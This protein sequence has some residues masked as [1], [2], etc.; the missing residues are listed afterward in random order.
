MNKKCII[1]GGGTRFHV[2]NHL[3][4]G[5]KAGGSTA[6]KI[7]ELVKA[8]PLNRMD[9]DLR[10]TNMALGGHEAHDL[11]TPDDVRRVAYEVVNDPLTKVVFMNCAIVDFEWQCGDVPAGKYSKRL[12]THPTNPPTPHPVME[13][14]FTSTK[15]LPIFR[16]ERNEAGNIRKDIF[17]VAFKATCGDTN[18]VMFEKG[19]KCLKDN[20]ANLVLVNDTK[21]RM[22]MIITPEEAV[23]HETTNRDE[24][25]A[26]LV[27]MTLHRSQL[28]FTQS[29]VID[30]SPVSWDDPQIPNSLREVVDFCIAQ[31]AYKPMQG[32]TVGHF[33][34]K[35][36]DQTF[37]TSKR[38]SNFNKLKE[39]GLVKIV[40]DG[41]DT[42]LA[43]GAKPSVGGQS[44]RM[45]FSDHPGMDCIVH[46]HCPLNEFPQDDI[47]VVSQ[48]EVECGSHQ[49]G[50]N[51]SNGLKDFGGFK[52]VML[53]QHG[54][55][56]VFPRDIDPS[57][58]IEFITNNF[59]LHEKTSG[60]HLPV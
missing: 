31:N 27:D 50:Q 30:G 59:N 44:Q 18:Q 6:R 48:R 29:T 42:V 20:S 11:D 14:M 54:P 58:I 51:T 37:L 23:Y 25:L 28:T 3:Y 57:R 33:A 1:L 4:V 9:V 56:I 10:L 21:R 46:F 2:R 55:N 38:K 60:Y 19:L 52:C 32:A 34:A 35:L 13:V 39:I 5:A 7:A 16:Q 53:D 40:T 47:P 41:P 49:C 36:D 15:I 43:Y 26:G 12:S 8:H 22:N 24:V 17:L 45:V